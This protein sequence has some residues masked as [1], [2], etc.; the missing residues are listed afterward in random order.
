MIKPTA[1]QRK[2][3]KEYWA[4]FRFRENEWHE[5]IGRLEKALERETGIRELEFFRNS[6]G[7]YVGIGNTIKTMKLINDYQLDK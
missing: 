6:F 1:K 4:E 2:L 7:E 5:S 3:M